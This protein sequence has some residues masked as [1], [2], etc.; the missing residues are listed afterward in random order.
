M[1]EQNEAQIAA[2]KQAVNRLC[3]RAGR[4]L[5]YPDVMQPAGAGIGNI[6]PDQYYGL[7][8]ATAI[9]SILEARRSANLGAAT[10]R[11]IFD[12]LVK[13]GF[14]F[15]AKDENALRLLV[16]VLEARHAALWAQQARL[17]LSS[18]DHLAAAEPRLCRLIAVLPDGH[19]ATEAEIN[20]LH[21]A[22]TQT[23]QQ[24]QHDA[25][26]DYPAQRNA[27]VEAHWAALRECWVT[28]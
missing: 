2:N 26:G 25:W 8:L 4:P 10:V 23:R 9:R 13:G 18:N 1:I 15:E 21:T 19:L 12:T 6:R 14:K 27:A 5:L 24:I 22:P 16:P 28:D 3:E 20:M 7:Q 17:L 11:E